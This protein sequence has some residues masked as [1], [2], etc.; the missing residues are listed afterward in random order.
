MTDNKWA[1]DAVA[2]PT[3][4]F[5]ARFVRLWSLLEHVN[6]DDLAEDRMEWRWSS[7]G[8]YSSSSAYRAF[9]SG[10]TTMRGMNKLWATSA[11]PKVKFFFWLALHGR[12]WMVERRKR[13]GLQP[14]DDCVLCA[15]ESESSDH[16]FVTCVFSR[17]LWHRLLVTIGFTHLCPSTNDRLMDWW[18]SSRSL[19][20]EGYRRGFDSLVLLM[21]WMIWK[22]RNRRTFDH[23]SCTPNVVLGCVREE[24]DAWVIA[25]F[26]AFVPLF[27]V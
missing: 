21:T 18:L 26:R 23:V 14:N 1:W 24:G 2:V 16:L 13:H 4:R 5:I 10:R 27:A 15:Q 9:F 22:V 19:V 8:Q 17:E 3:A 6:L 25:R 7:D 12:L 20:P 11:P